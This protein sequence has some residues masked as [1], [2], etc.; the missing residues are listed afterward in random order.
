[1]DQ[2]AG[3][4]LDEAKQ[5]HD[6]FSTTL[7]HSSE[8]PKKS[9]AFELKREILIQE[10]VIGTRITFESHVLAADWTH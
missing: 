5:S 7:L 1:M 3:P 10:S 2:G 4:F 9:A 6:G 8:H